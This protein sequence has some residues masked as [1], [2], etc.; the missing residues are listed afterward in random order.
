MNTVDCIILFAV[1]AIVG[2]VLLYIRRAK[3]KGIQ[4]IGCPDSAKCSGHCQG[5][6]GGC[7][8]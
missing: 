4:C 5:C 1:A 7:N 6:S 3:K 8:K 2:A